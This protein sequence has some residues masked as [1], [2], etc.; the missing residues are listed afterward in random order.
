MKQPRVILVTGS[1][2]GF[3]RLTVETLA[4]QGHQ[5]YASMR[6]VTGRNAEPSTQLREL[7]ER[8][9]LSIR[10]VE[11]DVTDDASVDQAVGQ[12]IR[13][14]DRIDVLVNNAGSVFIGH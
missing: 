6:D 12:V 13:Q 4:R 2:S 9:G 11:L 10:I 8:E 5:V 3:G 14:V 7:A 1:S